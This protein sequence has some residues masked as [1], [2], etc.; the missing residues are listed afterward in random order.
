MKD[1]S[2]IS[3]LFKMLNPKCIQNIKIDTTMKYLEPDENSTGNHIEH[4]KLIKTLS[5]LNNCETLHLN[6]ILNLVNQ[7]DVDGYD[8]Q[9]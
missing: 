1:D 3:L 8:F 5:Y 6:N 4:E 7:N 2:S 9:M